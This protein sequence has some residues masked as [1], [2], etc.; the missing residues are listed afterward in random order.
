[1]HDL[2]LIGGRVVSVAT[3]EI[4]ESD[5]VIDG[6][7]VAALPGPDSAV[8]ARETID[9]TGLLVVPGFI[10]SHMHIESSMLTPTTFAA[11]T[12]PRGTTTVLADPHEIVNVAGADGL[13][14]MIEEGAKTQ[15]SMFW[16][17]PSCVPSLDGLET[18]GASLS[19][20]DIDELLALEG[21]IA[22]GEVMDYRA[23]IAGGERMRGIL[24]V[25]Q[26]HDVIID[27]HCPELAGSELQRYLLAGIDSDHC[28]NSAAA[29]GEKL[30]FGMTMMLQ[31]K[32]FT[33]EVVEYLLELPQ[34]PDLC[35]VTDDISA[36]AIQKHGH[37]DHLARVARGAGLPSLAILRALTLNPARRLRLHDRG[38]IA[39]GKRADLVLLTDLK[40]FE[41]VDV[42]VGGQRVREQPPSGSA[43]TNSLVLRQHAVADQRWLSDLPDGE[44][45][46]RAIRVNSVDTS[47]LSDTIVLPV[48]NGIVEWEGRCARVTV[49]ERY[50]GSG[51][52]AHAPVLGMELADGAVATSYAHDSHNLTVIGTSAAQTA[53][54]AERV[55]ELGGGIVVCEGE[56]SKTH[57][58]SAEV[59]LPIGGLMTAAP[60]AE[61][62]HAAGEI[63][64][65]LERW[66]WRHRIPFMSVSTLTLPVSPALKISD[67]GLIDVLE[68]RLVP[69]TV[70]VPE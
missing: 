13:R 30:R 14:W 68:R 25:A 23:V 50:E 17:V 8:S 60:L 32:S 2:K 46:F 45:V 52:T 57:D 6:E 38:V 59:V 40:S 15:Q 47:T 49:Y 36:D 64:A 31:E 62:A 55:I 28:K 20:A 24:E 26:R 39:P 63:R 69:A 51:R 3:G 54:A 21:V 27:G 65:A 5:V 41:V 42:I 70:S 1:M 29:I 22:L 37:L 33:P 10:D 9:A 67:F 7:R 4:W 11:A 56:T 16:A 48:H 18:A 61:V 19:A 12:L 34:L 35:I 66:G 44:H 58:I 53:R 43:F